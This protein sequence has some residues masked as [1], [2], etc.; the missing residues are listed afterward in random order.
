MHV[1]NVNLKIKSNSFKLYEVPGDRDCTPVFG[2]RLQMSASATCDLYDICQ[3]FYIL[4]LL[5]AT[6]VFRYPK[7]I[8][9]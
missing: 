5:S 7:F 4:F 3:S 1:N 9:H 2:K 8:R 6:I